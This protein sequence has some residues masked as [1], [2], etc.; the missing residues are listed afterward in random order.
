MRTTYLLMLEPTL[1][2]GREFD[3]RA[4]RLRGRER[5]TTYPFM[6]E[7]TLHY[8]REFD[9]KAGGSLPIIKEVPHKRHKGPFLSAAKP[10]PID[11]VLKSMLFFLVFLTIPCLIYKL[12]PLLSLLRAPSFPCVGS[13]PSSIFPWKRSCVFVRER[14]EGGL[15]VCT[16]NMPGNL[17]TFNNKGECSEKEEL[18]QPLRFKMGQAW[19]MRKVFFS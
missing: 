2:F 16:I 5:I 17:F 9:S 18:R 11:V 10:I 19:C 7:P 6:L 3:S 8:G 14:S 13:A 1:H 4:G 15:S 12:F